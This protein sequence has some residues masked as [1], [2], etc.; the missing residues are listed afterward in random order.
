MAHLIGVFFGCCFR[1]TL[2]EKVTEHYQGPSDA[3]YGQE[4]SPLCGPSLISFEILEPFFWVGK[5]GARRENI[6]ICMYV[7]VPYIYKQF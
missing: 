4:G 1:I 2:D 3:L 5:P 7:Y 6:Y